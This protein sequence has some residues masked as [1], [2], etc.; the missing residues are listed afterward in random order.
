MHYNRNRRP[1]Q[2]LHTIRHNRA[3][4]SGSGAGGVGLAGNRAISRNAFGA[5]VNKNRNRRNRGKDKKVSSSSGSDSVK[6]QI[7]K[8]KI[9]E[10]EDSDEESGSETKPAISN[11]EKKESILL[12]TKM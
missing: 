1:T 5:K 10:E 6:K 2:V 7:E 3:N 9:E 8:L 11:N 12:L 4:Q